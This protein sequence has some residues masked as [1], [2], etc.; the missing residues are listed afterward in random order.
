MSAQ[1]PRLRQI[2]AKLRRVERRDWW[3][4]GA[5]ALI[6]LLLLGA[7]ASLSLPGLFATDFFFEWNLQIAV[8]G[9]TGMVLLFNLYAVYQ[10]LI[11]K[12]L[13]AQLARQ[14]SITAQLEAKADQLNELA[15]RDPLTDLYNRRFAD[16]HLETETARA[17]RTGTPLSVL[18]FDLCD[19]K[20]INDRFGHA[21]GD[22]A[23]QVF[24]AH[25]KQA[26]RE[27]DILVRMGGDE[28]MAVLPDC[29]ATE[30][31]F[32][33]ER[34][35]TVT[36]EWAQQRIQIRNAVG[37]AQL[38]PRETSAQLLQ[39]ADQMM[40]THKRRGKAVALLSFQQSAENPV[41]VG[42]GE[43]EREILELRANAS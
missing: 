21:A 38:R 42:T 1:T 15:L 8:R 36:M 43:V 22:L 32:L 28:F 18:L 23:L 6:T 31:P 33:V 9:L 25:L 37:W 19:F 30:V 5:T 4:W 40:Y 35:G 20:Q 7:V 16:R 12:R 26:F 39:R 14:L 3:L 41:R 11:I 17:S 34:L 2:E 27:T 29:E 13:R 10:K 24:A